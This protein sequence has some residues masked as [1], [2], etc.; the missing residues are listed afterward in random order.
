[1]KGVGGEVI[2]EAVKARPDR[3]GRIRAPGTEKVKGNFG[4]GK[5]AVPEVV[6]EVGVGGGEQGDEVIFSRP[7][8]SLRRN[9]PVNL[10]GHKLH[11]QPLRGKVLAL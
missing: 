6:G 5:K 4:V 3:D 2:G 9:G 10:W 7:H 11:R 8:C 1:M